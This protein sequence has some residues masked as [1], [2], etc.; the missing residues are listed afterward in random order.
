M[1][2]VYERVC[3]K[4]KIV[5]MA[6]FLSFLC[7]DF[8]FSFLAVEASETWDWVNGKPLSLACL[9]PSVMR[10]LLT[11]EGCGAPEQG[12]E[13]PPKR[14]KT[15]EQSTK[16]RAKRLVH[17]LQHGQRVFTQKILTISSLHMGP[18]LQCVPFR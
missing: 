18:R 17:L 1:K 4:E 8:P 16:G 9:A 12:E 15:P 2:S 3:Q 14:I 11:E 7:L 6:S 10:Q 13:I 5:R